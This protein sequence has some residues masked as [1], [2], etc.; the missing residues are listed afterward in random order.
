MCIATSIVGFSLNTL[1]IYERQN[2][3]NFKLSLKLRQL[4]NRLESMRFFNTSK[5]EVCA[6]GEGVW[7]RLT[8]ASPKSIRWLAGGGECGGSTGVTCGARI[9]GQGSN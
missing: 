7:G 2:E 6:C 8:E 4:K 9:P 1:E 3:S 5:Q